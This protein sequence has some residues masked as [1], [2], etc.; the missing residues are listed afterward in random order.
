[1][2]SRQSQAAS[3][4]IPK[5]LWRRVFGWLGKGLVVILLI[6]GLI[7]LLVGAEKWRRRQ[8]TFNK[9]GTD[10]IMSKNLLGMKFIKQEIKVDDVLFNWKPTSPE[11]INYFQIEGSQ[12]EIFDKLVQFAKDNGWKNLSIYNVSQEDIRFSA[13]KSDFTLHTRVHSINKN[14][15]SVYIR[16]Q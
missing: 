5:P 7:L 9:L 14:I 1:M 15:L 13:R 3:R 2:T 8:E 11:I 12:K 16:N 4:P 6:L 10:P